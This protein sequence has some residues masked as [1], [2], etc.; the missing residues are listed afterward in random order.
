MIY[1]ND[2]S[3]KS[4]R[5]RNYYLN[6]YLLPIGTAAVICAVVYWASE[7][8]YLSKGDTY[9]GYF[10]SLTAALLLYGFHKRNWLK[11][12]DGSFWYVKGMAAAPK[13]TINEPAVYEAEYYYSKKDK[14]ITTVA[15]VAS[16]AL[17]AWLFSKGSTSILIPAVT[18]IMGV[19]LTYTG[20]KELREK[21]ARL[22]IARNGL[23]TKHLGFM[24]WDDI[25]FADVVEDKT[26]D[27]PT[28]YLEIYLKGTDFEKAN[29]P[30]E[31]L[32][33]SDLKDHDMIDAVIRD[34]ITNYN[35]QKKQ[36][37]N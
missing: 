24:N 15:G 9:Y 11:M 23:W 26:S 27:S 22:K 1:T 31:R 7:N 37:G 5:K 29:V 12:P 28:Q 16:I 18:S 10:L 32:L 13:L 33:L 17:S 14:A 34:S 3:D 21:T 30:D 25:N 6:V 36:R 19:F 2:E 35:N 4:T 8:N 20:I